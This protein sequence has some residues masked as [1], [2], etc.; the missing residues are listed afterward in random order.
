MDGQWLQWVR[1]VVTVQVRGGEPERLVN[2]ALEGG[3]QLASILWT[4]GGKLQFELS[5]DDYF[6][7]RKHL[8]ETGCRAHVT[9][10]KGLPFW[11]VKVE[12]RKLFVTGIALFFAGVYLLSSLVWTIEVKGNVKL[13]E[14]QIFAAAKQ[15]GLFPMQWSFR[16]QDADVLSKKLV[17]KLPGATWIGVEKKGAKVIIQVVETTEP[18]RENLNNPRHLVASVDAVVTQIYAEKGRAVVKKN[19]KVKQGQTLI[20]GTIGGGAYTQTVVAKGE[21]RGLVW[22]EFDIASPLTQ[23]VK[24]YTGEKKTKWYA[25]I[26]GRALQVSGFGKNPFD[27]FETVVYE[28][29][30]AWRQWKLPFG[31]LK[32]TTMEVRTDERNLTEEEAKSAG[33]QR[34]KADAMLQAG[35]DAVIRNEIVLHEKTDNGKVY[36]KVLFEVEQSIVKEMPL[37]QMQGE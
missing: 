35:P 8:K 30:A 28:E 7:L 31:R 24:A 16:L 18:E 22:Y 27:S 5:V 36:M 17:T 19:M 26:G 1:G 25:M 29:Q 2:R 3:L 23:Q 14:E 21:V 32:K 33:M 34:A 37:V 4:S 6:K 15:E 12:K 13:T 20:S 11:L 9:K 10:R